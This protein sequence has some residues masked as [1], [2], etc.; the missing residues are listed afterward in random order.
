MANLLHSFP[1]LL[2]P[3]IILGGIM[4]GVVTPTES[5]VVAVVYGLLLGFFVYKQLKP[6][7]LPQIL[8]EVVLTSAMIMFIVANASIFAWVIT[9]QQFPQDLGALLSNVSTDPLFIL[10][11]FI[12][13]FLVVGTFLDTSAAL[14]IITPV[15]IPIAQAANIDMVHFGV[16]TVITLAIGLATPPVGLNLF[17]ASGIANSGIVEASKGLLP[18]LIGMIAIVILLA[19]FPSLVTFLPSMLMK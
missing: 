19:L 13:V 12:A 10:L 8:Y 5:A 1:A 6:S 4:L 15:L 7:D 17:V 11:I 18:F 3:V 2:M 14:I 9:S 16:I